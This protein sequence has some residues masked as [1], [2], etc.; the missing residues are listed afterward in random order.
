MNVDLGVAP[1]KDQAFGQRSKKALSDLV[2][3]K[4]VILEPET[5]DK[6]GRTVARVV[7]NGEDANLR[8]VRSGMAWVYDQ[9]AREPHY[10]DAQVS[11]R[12]ANVGLWDDPNPIRPSDWRHGGARVS[13][14]SAA[15]APVLVATASGGFTCSGKRYCREMGSC[16]EA[17]FYLTQ[18]GLSRLDGDGDGVPCEKMCR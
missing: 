12:S 3:G 2:F 13:R 8:M 5:T 10:F 7:V 6:Y 11:A 17:R 14:T 18:C 4:Q 1:E 16:A 15:A 9:Y